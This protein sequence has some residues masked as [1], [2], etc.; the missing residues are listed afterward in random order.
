[1]VTHCNVRWDQTGT[2]ISDLSNWRHGSS[3]RGTIVVWGKKFFF[4]IIGFCPFFT[5][6]VKYLT[7][8]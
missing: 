2:G 5:P 3:A 6:L 4:Q 7:Y 8:K 1:M